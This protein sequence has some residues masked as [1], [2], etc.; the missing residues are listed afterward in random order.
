MTYGNKYYPKGNRE[1]VKGNRKTPEKKEEG[2]R[3]DKRKWRKKTKKKE[4]VKRN[5]QECVSAL[6]RAY[7]N[8]IKL[9]T[10]ENA[11]KFFFTNFHEQ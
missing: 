6:S 8:F 1:K 2:W 3:N 10:I 7:G 11:A 9:L 5:K 4:N